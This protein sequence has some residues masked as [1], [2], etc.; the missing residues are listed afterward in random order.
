MSKNLSLVAVGNLYV[1]TNFLGIET[2][3]SDVLESGKE[4]SAPLYELRLGGSAVNFITQ[5]KRLGLSVGIIGKTGVDDAQKTLLKLFEKEGV[6]T[7]LISSS[8]DVQTNIDSGIIFA[9]SG[10]NIQFVAGS[11]NESLALSD[12]PLDNPELHKAS[13]I[14]FG[15]SFKQRLLWPHYPE[16]FKKLF[17]KDVKIFLDPGRVPVDASPEWIN[18][19]TEILPYTYCYFPND[20]E[21]TSV[22]KVKE[23]SIAI[24]KIMAS[25]P[26]YIAVKRGPEGC[27]AASKDSY[28][29]VPGHKIKPISTVGAGDSFNAAFISQLLNEKDLTSCGLYANACAALRVST[30]S[31][32]YPK[33]IEKFMRTQASNN[34]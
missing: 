11:A 19:L 4:Y 13:G 34:S 32:P 22:T 18:I 30:N 23:L 17:Q 2:K 33:D 8:P 12:I 24:K 31:Q 10:Q 14:Y 27:I 28:F 16:I 3:E 21:I 1:E 15:G 7:T 26:Q 9:H 5:S 29:E 25:G 6:K 20:M